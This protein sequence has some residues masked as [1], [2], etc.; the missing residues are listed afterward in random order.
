MLGAIGYGGLS[1]TV[2]NTNSFYNLDESADDASDCF[3][4]FGQEMLQLAQSSG[5]GTPFGVPYGEWLA[6]LPAMC[7]QPR[8]SRRQPNFIR[9]YCDC[10]AAQVYS[11]AAG[12]L[13]LPPSRMQSSA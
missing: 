5:V 4:Y 13:L 7:Q 1:S 10:C 3:A 11:L 6:V 12:R 2:G 9:S 8:Q